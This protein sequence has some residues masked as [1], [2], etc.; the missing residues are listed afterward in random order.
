LPRLHH[1]ARLSSSP[2]DE[3]SSTLEAALPLPPGSDDVLLD[4]VGQGL[5]QVAFLE[6]ENRHQERL[7]GDH[8]LNARVRATQPVEGLPH[9]R[10]ITRM[11]KERVFQLL[12]V[13]AHRRIPR[14]EGCILLRTRDT[15]QAVLD[16]A[17]GPR[18][19]ATPATWRVT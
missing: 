11:L 15:R 9:S 18:S 3:L 12:P 8:G 2:S 7:H 17:V 19:R 1:S 16:R 4:P 13:L 5:S 10:V 6:S 14:D